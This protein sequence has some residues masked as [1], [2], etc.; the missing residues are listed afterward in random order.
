L[1]DKK[2]NGNTVSPMPA[3]LRPK[4]V[5]FMPAKNFSNIPIDQERG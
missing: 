1:L 2:S 4:A 3:Q 5:A